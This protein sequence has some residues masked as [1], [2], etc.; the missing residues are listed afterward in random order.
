M[1]TSSNAQSR[2]L[3]TAIKPPGYRV[4]LI[5]PG[6]DHSASDV[7]VAA[8]LRRWWADA[9][10]KAAATGTGLSN[11]VKEQPA[12]PTLKI[13]DIKPNVFFDLCAQ[14]VRVYSPA[15]GSGQA[16]LLLTDYTANQSLKDEIVAIDEHHLPIQRHMVMSCTLWDSHVSQV[17]DL[18]TGQH[19]YLRNLRGKVDRDGFLEAMMH[20]ERSDDAKKTSVF[21]LDAAE[22]ADRATAANDRFKSNV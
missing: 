2:L 15:A 8:F 1:G 7:E 16:V 17:A 11:L 21:V 12:R 22:P 19:I 4:S 14:I 20:G 3:G 5:R 10:A 13:C 6:H 9:L 18:R